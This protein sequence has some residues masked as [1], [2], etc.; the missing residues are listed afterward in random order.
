MVDPGQEE[1][2]A[3]SL[4]LRI[5]GAARGVADAGLDRTVGP[6]ALPG[7]ADEGLGVDLLDVGDALAPCDEELAVE[8]GRVGF[9]AL[10]RCRRDAATQVGA[11]EADP[12]CAA[13]DAA[14]HLDGVAEADAVDDRDVAAFCGD[15]VFGDAVRGRDASA[16]GRARVTSTQ[17]VPLKVLA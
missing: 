10:G 14:I 17:A 2:V 7:P 6:G 16:R 5:E 13:A 8:P 15:V 1:L 12:G 9:A 3:G 11:A 4:E